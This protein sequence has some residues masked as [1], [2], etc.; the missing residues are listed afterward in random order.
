MPR[1]PFK[2][3]PFPRSGDPNCIHTFP[4]KGNYCSK[5]GMHWNTLH[6]SPGTPRTIDCVEYMEKGAG[7]RITAGCSI[8][9]KGLTFAP[10]FHLD[11]RS[12]SLRTG[13]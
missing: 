7:W 10:H 1:D 3:E 5:C 13:A 4:R 6:P 11:P 2:P 8:A 12:F 9:T